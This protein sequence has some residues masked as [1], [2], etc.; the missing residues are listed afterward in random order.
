MV[1]AGEAQQ[2]SY[3]DQKRSYL[4]K[5]TSKI[6]KNYVKIEFQDKC[7]QGGSMLLWEPPYCLPISHFEGPGPWRS[8]ETASFLAKSADQSI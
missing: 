1:F 8:L 4:I 7:D 3:F 2:S 6:A 5:I